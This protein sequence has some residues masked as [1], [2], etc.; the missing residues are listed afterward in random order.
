MSAILV[1]QTRNGDKM[2]EYQ[3]ATPEFFMR[4]GKM[5]RRTFIKGVGAITVASAFGFAAKPE[6][7]ARV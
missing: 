4:D 2:E 3:G 7:G 6:G 5:N 1:N